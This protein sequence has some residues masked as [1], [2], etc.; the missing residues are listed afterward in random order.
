LS[1][2]KNDIIKRKISWKYKVDDAISKKIEMEK[3]MLIRDIEK[4]EDQLSKKGLITPHFRKI[5]NM[6]KVHLEIQPSEPL[7]DKILHLL[8]KQNDACSI[9]DLIKELIKNEIPVT[10][11]QV[12][13]KIFELAKKGI[14]FVHKGIIFSKKPSDTKYGKAI[15]ELLQKRKIVAKKELLDHF[16]VPQQ[17]LDIIIEDLLQTGIIVVD[18]KDNIILL[19]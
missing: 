5:F 13:R 14:L 17:L 7:E 9:E 3:K 8:K 12:E 6:I 2:K 19:G 15:L 16:N 11:Q 10:R 18:D 1:T 4:I